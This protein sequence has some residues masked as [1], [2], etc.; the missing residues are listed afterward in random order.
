MNASSVAVSAGGFRFVRVDLW[1]AAALLSS[2]V[3]IVWIAVPAMGAERAPRHAGHLPLLYAHVVGGIGMLLA[4]ALAL[5]IGAT[6]Q[7]FRHHRL[8][9][10]TYLVTGTVAA[11]SALVRS[12]D[13]GHTPGLSTGTLAAVWLVFAALAWRA[14][15]NRRYE[16]HRDWMIRSYVAGWTFVFCRFFERAVPPDFKGDERDMIWLTWVGPL[17]LT[18]VLLQWRHGA[19]ARR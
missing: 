5:R 4:G 13:V 18:E 11:G 17:L 3:F 7:F 8:V 6:R 15:R 1:I 16:Q 14:V 9:G 12:F 19:A 10:A 2:L